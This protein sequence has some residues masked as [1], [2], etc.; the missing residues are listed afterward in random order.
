MDVKIIGGN[1][2]RSSIG[3]AAYR[4]GEKLYNEY[5]GTT[6]DYTKRRSSVHAS[7]YRSGQKLNNHDFTH[8]GGIVH[9]EIM[10]PPHAPTSFYDRSTLWNAV[11][12]SE[13]NHNAR[14]GREIVVALPN[15]LNREQQIAI[16]RDYVQ[17]NF[18]NKGMCADF[19]IHA[20]HIHDR[21]NEIYPF[22]NLTVRKDN[23]HAHIQLTV[24]PLN[25]NGTW[26]AKSKK[27]YI[28]D[29]NG[30]RIKLPSGNYKSRKVDS[31]DWDKTDTLLKWRENWSA[32]VNQEFAR[33]GIT[34]RID[35][36][37]LKA[38]GIN[39]EPTMHMG[40]KAWNLEKQGIRTRT[41][42]INRQIMA[43][44]KERQAREKLASVQKQQVIQHMNKLNKNYTTLKNQILEFHNQLN[45][46]EREI[47]KM[48]AHI[49]SLQQR[50]SDISRQHD[51]LQQAYAVRVG[52]KDKKQ[53][54][55]QINRLEDTYRQSWEYYQQTFRITPNEGHQK[56]EQLKHQCEKAY[57]EIYALR[58]TTDMRLYTERLREI[59]T[60]YKRQYLLV[61]NRPDSRE[62]LQSLDRADINLQRISDDDIREV[63][64]NM[65]PY[66]AD[67]L[68]HRRYT[69]EQSRNF[70]DRAR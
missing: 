49:K 1:K 18:V 68:Q 38:Q 34:E 56:I 60:E 31:T 17:R 9:N 27:E 2:G 28:L 22:L 26:G 14:T 13:R 53:I 48:E 25:R 39:R 41:G 55:A 7:A 40:H 46:R 59:E 43:R 33:L 62:I 3:V 65:P 45:Q 15:E 5:N 30:N 19:S 52:I 63:T 66:Q 4:T 29:R 16:V 47:A 20:G 12:Q 70:Y 24:R 37:T 67:M 23:P 6:H 54:N 42:I 50:T 51:N 35:H 58:C 10:L 57:H 21:K 61:E 32:T 36:R 11:E 69:H 64:Q 44:N 8:K